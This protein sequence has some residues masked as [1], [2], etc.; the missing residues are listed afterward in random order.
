MKVEQYIINTGMGKT[1]DSLPFMTEEEYAEFNLIGYS[2]KGNDGI[3]TTRI[4][5][6]QRLNKGS[7]SISQTK[8]DYGDF[9]ER[10][11]IVRSIDDNSNMSHIRLEK[12][13]LFVNGW[14]PYDFNAMGQ[15]AVKIYYTDGDYQFLTTP[16]DSR[17]GN[18]GGDFKDEAEMIAFIS[19]LE[20][21]G[22]PRNWTDND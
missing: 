10:F 22:I 2:G 11:I 21:K 14:K 6:L 20:S 16:I 15:K 1:R 4:D 7:F 13:I 18:D 9:S 3:R 19:Y 5:F 17:I 12:D 8:Y